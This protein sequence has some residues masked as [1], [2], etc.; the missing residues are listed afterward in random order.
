VAGLTTFI[1]HTTLHDDKN[2]RVIRK[3]RETVAWNWW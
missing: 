1:F 3:W 2:V